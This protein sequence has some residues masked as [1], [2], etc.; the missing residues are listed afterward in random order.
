M[1]KYLK[2]L[3]KKKKIKKLQLERF[4]EPF[5]IFCFLSISFSILKFCLLKMGMF[6]R[7]LPCAFMDQCCQD[8]VHVEAH[9]LQKA[10]RARTYQLM[11]LLSWRTYTALLDKYAR[12]DISRYLIVFNDASRLFSSLPSFFVSRIVHFICFS[13]FLTIYFFISLKLL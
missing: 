8:I 1:R 7:C 5:Y 13:L 12:S 3:L 11:E 10:D 6:F 2:R 4:D 9:P